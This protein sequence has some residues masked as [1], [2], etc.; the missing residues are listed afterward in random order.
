MKAFL[1]VTSTMDRWEWCP[2]SN[3]VIAE[4]KE[5]AYDI[6]DSKGEKLIDVKEIDLTVKGQIEIQFS[7]VE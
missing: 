4:S 5:E 1:F 6:F 7:M 3:L 2:T